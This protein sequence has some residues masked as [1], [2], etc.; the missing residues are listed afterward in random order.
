MSLVAATLA[1][2]YLSAGLLCLRV[3]RRLPADASARGDPAETSRVGMLWAGCGLALALLSMLALW[4]L[5]LRLGDMLRQASRDDG[6]YPLRR[7]FQAAALVAGLW[8]VWKVLRDVLPSGASGPLLG[9]VASTLLLAFVVWGR[10]V[11]WHWMDSV[12]NFRWAGASTGRWFEVTG[13]LAVAA[14]AVWQRRRDTCASSSL[15][16]PGHASPASQP[17]QA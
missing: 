4:G 6:W 14:F 13:L 15:A 2:G 1:A 7:P 16:G 17:S 11:S 8:L 3:A 5:D 9:C 12:L 10:F